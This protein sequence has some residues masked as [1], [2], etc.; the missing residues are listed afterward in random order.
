MAGFMWTVSFQKLGKWPKLLTFLSI[1]R[2]AYWGHVKVGQVYAW[3]HTVNYNSVERNGRAGGGITV[4]K[5]VSW[6][7]ERLSVSAGTLDGQSVG[8]QNLLSP[9]PGVVYYSVSEIK[10][11]PC[12]RWA[13]FHGRV[14]DFRRYAPG[15][16]TFFKPV[17]IAT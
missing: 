14:H 15:V 6:G 8:T 5:R 13:H 11:A 2:Q 10:G 17:T 3:H 12:A 9:T 1:V 7:R 16:C 4:S